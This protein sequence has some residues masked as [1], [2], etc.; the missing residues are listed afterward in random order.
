MGMACDDNVLK[1]LLGQHLHIPLVFDNTES[2]RQAYE[3]NICHGM[4]AIKDSLLLTTPFNN[5]R[6]DLPLCLETLRSVLQKFAGQVWGAF[7]LGDGF[8]YP[9]ANLI[10]FGRDIIELP[11]TEMLLLQELSRHDGQCV[12]RDHLMRTVWKTDAPL[13]TRTLESHIYQLRQKLPPAPD[14]EGWIITT[15]Q[16]YGLR[17]VN[18]GKLPYKRTKAS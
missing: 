16:G 1:D 7:R 6:L 11:A 4:L 10:R 14:G 8:V 9:A 13:E 5:H 18:E 3:N 17:I 2:L 15:P 12:T